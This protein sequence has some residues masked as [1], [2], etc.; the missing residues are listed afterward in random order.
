VKKRRGRRRRRRGGG[1]GRRRRGGGRRRGR[2]GR[3]KGE[4]EE[5]D[6]HIA[7]QEE[8]QE[9]RHV[10]ALDRSFVQ[11]WAAEGYGQRVQHGGAAAKYQE[12]GAAAG[13]AAA[14]AAHLCL[15]CMP[16]HMM[17]GLRG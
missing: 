13:A 3:E 11:R 14:A 5:E 7:L 6:I 12:L 10:F 4:E 15:A 2:R 1:R 17:Y 8:G 16:L 9:R